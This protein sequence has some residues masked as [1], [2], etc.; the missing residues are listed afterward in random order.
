MHLVDSF[1]TS[2]TIV[3]GFFSLSPNDGIGDDQ[4]IPLLG[5]SNNNVEIQ[6]HHTKYQEPIFKPPGGSLSGPGSD[7]KCDYNDTMPQW[8]PCSTPENRTCW[9]KNR[10]TNDTFD[11]YTDYES[12]TPN[13]TYRFYELDLTDDTVINA[14]GVAFDHAKL[15]DRQYPGTWIQ[16]CWGDVCFPPCHFGLLELLLILVMIECYG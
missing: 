8:S 7:F 2:V 1:W 6:H 10:E 3:V 9:L 14:D 15:F 12:K 16:A 4:Q 5:P 13:G 11:I